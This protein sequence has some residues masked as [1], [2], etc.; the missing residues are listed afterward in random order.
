[1]LYYKVLTFDSSAAPL[2]RHSSPPPSLLGA[3]RGSGEL[4]GQLSGPARH[5]GARGA[6]YLQVMGQ[7]RRKKHPYNVAAIASDYTSR[8]GEESKFA[9]HSSSLLDAVGGVDRRVKFHKARTAEGGKGSISAPAQSITNKNKIFGAEEEN[10]LGFR[11]GHE[12]CSEESVDSLLLW[13][14]PAGVGPGFYNLGNTCFLNSTLQCLV[15]LPALAQHFMGASYGGFVKRMDGRE[16]LSSDTLGLLSE[17]V[18]RVH[19][20]KK[21]KGGS[22]AISPKAIV[23][24]IR[25]IGKQFRPGR[26]EDAHEFLR[27]LVDGM[28]E[29]C[30]KRSGVKGSAPHRLAETTPIHRIFAGYLR[31][32]LQCVSCGFTS[33]TFDMAMDLSLDMHKGVHNLE[34]ALRRFQATETLDKANRWKC[35]G[36][37]KLVCA[38]KHLTIHTS[39]R[40][41]VLQLKRFAY[42]RHAGKIK[43]FL[44]YPEVLHLG[45]TGEERRT[46][47]HLT[48]VLVHQGGSM[49]FGHY[50]SFVR[51]ANGMWHRMDDEGV[52]SARIDT[53][54][55]QIAY[56]LFYSKVPDHSED[57]TPGRS[58]KAV[59][60]GPIPSRVERVEDM[61]DKQPYR[62]NQLSP[63]Q[64]EKVQ[65]RVIE[66][67][68]SDEDS[69]S[70]QSRLAGKNSAEEE[71]DHEDE[72]AVPPRFSGR[73]HVLFVRPRT[74][75]R[76]HIRLQSRGV[77][78]Y[79][80]VQADFG[81]R[82]RRPKPSFRLPERAPSDSSPSSGEETE[83]P[84]IP[85]IAKRKEDIHPTAMNGS[86]SGG[87]SKSSSSV[88]RDEKV[89]VTGR[90]PDVAWSARNRR[91]RRSQVGKKFISSE[92]MQHEELGGWE[93]LDNEQEE[94]AARD[95]QIATELTRKMA[96][97]ESRARRDRALDNWDLTLN[98]G[99]LK[100]TKK[101]VPISEDTNKAFHD[102]Q[103][104]KQEASEGHKLLFQKRKKLKRTRVS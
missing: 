93:G 73:A 85:F 54:L 67:E 18:G 78:I 57:L 72:F 58:L 35:H 20:G 83:V 50:F 80:M 101:Q 95:R 5:R 44:P 7:K 22:S 43:R 65:D 37:K 47:Y 97:A 66:D 68:R 25:R 8:R 74:R 45:T 39:P 21:G 98:M 61:G 16:V 42:G 103:L 2:A 17:L 77:S 92:H 24:G 34:E 6:S 33:S 59:P 60:P 96:S 12:L 90:K 36:C 102:A 100:K 89:E 49:T 76:A 91:D 15:Y 70:S 51:A 11:R 10:E 86:L 38:Q 69:S 40:V 19:T 46:K 88:S 23:A 28:A 3:S 13:R 84:P 41:L 32:Q 104:A 71:D 79:T 81:K 48:G 63:K 26:Q 27:L 4:G 62:Q 75:A 31:N 14:K 53:V 52:Q 87:P 82:K 99:K 64:N 29:S 56:V 94:Q 55:N 9:G 30:L 1:M